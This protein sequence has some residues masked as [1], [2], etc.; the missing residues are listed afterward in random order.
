MV[1]AVPLAARVQGGHEQVGADKRVQHARRPVYLQRGV[2]QRAGE[3]FERRGSHQQ[4][5]LLA[6]PRRAA[7]PR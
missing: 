2:A 7:P 4:V 5:T 6:A 1:A 3:P